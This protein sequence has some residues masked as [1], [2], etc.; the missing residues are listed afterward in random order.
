MSN[1][2][3]KEKIED[4]PRG[5]RGELGQATA[6]QTLKQLYHQ[7]CFKRVDAEDKHNPGKK[8]WIKN[9]DAPSLKQ[10]A[11]ELRGEN[12]DVAALWFNH[13]KGSANTKRSDAN[14]ASAKAA[15]T[16]TKME[17]RKKSAGSKSSSTTT[18]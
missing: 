3:T 17:R 15:G 1:E 2:E 18:K 14:I 16:A 10:F 8:V 5:E 9:P 11:R 7:A 13:K 12:L 6:A 4:R